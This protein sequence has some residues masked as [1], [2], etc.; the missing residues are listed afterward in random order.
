MRNTPLKAFS[1]SPLKDSGH[2]GK[3]G[4]GHTTVFG[5]KV[6]GPSGKEILESVKKGAK[7]FWPNIELGKTGIEA[8]KK[9]LSKKKYIGR[10]FKDK[11]ED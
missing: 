1:K 10:F 6:P 9:Y 3:K 11:E 5:K 8:A 2:G 4:H 7:S